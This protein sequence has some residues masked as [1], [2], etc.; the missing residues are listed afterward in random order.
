MVNSKIIFSL[1]ILV[2]FLIWPMPARAADVAPTGG[3]GRGAQ[4]PNDV[5]TIGR[6][7]DLGYGLVKFQYAPGQLAA[8]QASVK[9]ARSAGYRVM[10][11]VA[12]NH[13][14]FSLPA[15]D[16]QADGDVCPDGGTGGYNDFRNFMEKTTRDLPN[17]ELFE[18]GNEPNLDGEWDPAKWGPYSPI[19]FAKLVECG[20]K[21]VKTANPSARVIT[22]AFSPNGSPSGGNEISNMSLM[23]SALNLQNID[24]IGAHLYSGSNTPP[25]NSGSDIYRLGEVINAASSANKRIWVTEFG[26]QRC[27][28][29]ITLDVQKQYIDE[30]F[31]ALAVRYPTVEGMVVWNF[32]YGKLPGVSEEF[33]CYD[34]EGAAGGKT[35]TPSGAK[36]KIAPATN[37]ADKPKIVSKVVDGKVVYEYTGKA[38]GQNCP[39]PI[40]AAQSGSNQQLSAQSWGNDSSQAKALTQA[41]LP[42]EVNQSLGEQATTQVATRTGL[43]NIFSGIAQ[44]LCGT[45]GLFCQPNVQFGGDTEQATLQ[46]QALAQAQMPGDFEY[47]PATN[48]CT[49]FDLQS[50]DE[51]KGNENINKFQSFSTATNGNNLADLADHQRRVEECLAKLNFKVGNQQLAQDARVC[52]AEV[53]AKE[54]KEANFPAGVNPFPEKDPTA[55]Q[56]IDK[57]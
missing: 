3:I 45:F 10:V 51:T 50:N 21:G 43:N 5:P 34:V 48:D 54:M 1:L 56:V 44:A 9:A 27:D 2:V 37:V 31:K 30:A 55:A 28:A 38:Q 15:E 11:S 40:A 7:K 24:F 41:L 18:I 4:L 53:T 23:L 33:K 36:G 25:S 52:E 19:K 32:G 42:E 8:V 35:T 12:K 6:L 57:K 22:G 16:P 29:G 14:G 20:A 26:W 39:R 17:V 13:T 49:V 46:A 47:D